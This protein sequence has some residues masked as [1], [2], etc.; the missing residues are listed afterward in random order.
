MTTRA[1]PKKVLLR[2]PA[3]TTLVPPL[4]APRR[5][6][7]T[8]LDFRTLHL[9][10]DVATVLSEAFWH[11]IGAGPLQTIL[12]H[13]A[14]IRF[15]GRFNQE[16]RAVRRLADLQGD[17]LI[18]YVEWLDAQTTA[19]GT[20][21]GKATRASSYISLLKLLQWLVRCRPGLLGPIDWPVN[22]FP[23]RN[24]D[25]AARRTI[26]AGQLRD[27]LKAC[28][29]DIAQLRLMRERGRQLI[30][31]A[32]A[33]GATYRSAHGAVLDF[34]DREFHGMLPP[35]PVLYRTHNHFYHH[36]YTHGGRYTF[37]PY[38]YPGASELFPY[39][40]AIL[41]HTAG[42][43][44]A[45]ADMSLDC[46]Q[47][48]PLLD[49]REMLVWEK[50]RASSVQRRSFR[51]SDPFAPP[52][53]V[54]DV[55]DWTQRLRCRVP[56]AQRHRL[57]LM[58]TA[59]GPT[60]ATRV[61]FEGAL[62]RFVAAHALAPFTL[63][64]LRPGVLTALYRSTGD[65][66]AVKAVANHA[67]ISTTV[68][69]VRGPE[70]AVQHGLR[71]AALQSALIGHVDPTAGA[72]E[73][74]APADEPSTRPPP[75]AAVSVFGFSCK[76]PLAGLAPGT[77][78][79]ELCTNFLACLTCPNAIIPTDAPTLA[80]LLH[81]RDHLQAAAAHIH[82]ARWTAIYA[83]QLRILEEDLLPRFPGNARAQAD[84]LR[85]ALAPLLPLR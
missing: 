75:G 38:L 67:S 82:P 73:A 11:R 39:Y 85:T 47:P 71:M 48:I 25:T 54:R 5:L 14:R 74:R 12:D 49:D 56:R 78:R 30:Q 68:S 57:F 40:L 22:P 65:L 69:Y 7:E 29:H 53:L 70:V 35:S 63:G 23:W 51:T 59:Y 61:K 6:R 28:E 62:H 19:S 18:R 37:E 34:I 21:L 79:G 76:D 10:R 13:W 41:L 64:S 27:L 42:N 80:R 31:A 44:Q 60:V 81:A 84:R 33:A 77:R 8:I 43:S 24:R 26:S 36:I 58:K 2:R 72:A 52:A 32:R 50:P 20:P 45:I 3:P 66:R 1:R 83:P 15:F 46:L 55:I 17:I 9:P 4:D 16:T